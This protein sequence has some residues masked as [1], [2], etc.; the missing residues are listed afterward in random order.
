MGLV[1][2]GIEHIGFDTVELKVN[3]RD[4]PKTFK[5]KEGDRQRIGTI[6]NYDY[7]ID[8]LDINSSLSSVRLSVSKIDNQNLE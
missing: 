1:S 7:F 5:K 6:G 4:D 2:I 8:V 3:F